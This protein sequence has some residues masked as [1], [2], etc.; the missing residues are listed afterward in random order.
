MSTDV[1][2]L[3]TALKPAEKFLL[4]GDEY[5]MLS[6]DHLSVEDEALVVAWLSR[7]TLLATELAYER[8][9][10]KGKIIAKRLREARLKVIDFLT[11]LTK[12][13]AAGLPTSQQALLLEALAKQVK[14][15]EA[16]ED[17]DPEDTDMEVAEGDETTLVVLGGGGNAP[18]LD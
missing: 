1:L 4:D 11:T 6:T 13:Q 12:E 8:V 7:H 9:P 14:V 10:E 18:A 2:S 16:D 5:E 15:P 17:I 3:S